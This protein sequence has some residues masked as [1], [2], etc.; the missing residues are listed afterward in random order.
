VTPLGLAAW[1]ALLAAVGALTASGL[2]GARARYRPWTRPAAWAAWGAATLTLALLVEHVLSARLGLFYVWEN[3]EAGYPWWLRLAGVWG[4]QEGTFLLWAWGVLTVLLVED[5][6]T[7]GAPWRH[8]RTV[9]AAIAVL[10]LVPVVVLD[11]G[12]ETLAFGLTGEGQLVQGADGPSPLSLR[13]DGQ[14]L[15]PLLETV[16]MAVHPPLEFLGYA[17]VTAPFAYGLVGLAHGGEWRARAQAWGRVA[18]VVLLSALTL[19]ALWAYHV[20]SFGG[21]WIWDPVEV[22]NLLPLLALTV[23]LHAAPARARGHLGLLA[24]ATAALPLVMVVF[25]DFV[26]RTGLWSSVHAFLPTGVS[27]T[28][29]DPGRRLLAAV[30]GHVPARLATGL[31][32]ATLGAFGVAASLFHVRDRPRGSTASPLALAGALAFGAAG[33][34]GLVWPTVLVRALTPLIG[35]LGLGDPVVGAG[36][37]VV[38]A[39]LP[40]V[41]GLPA[42]PRELP[43]HPRSRA[44]QLVLACGALTVTL[45]ATVLLLVFGVN[46]YGEAVFTARAPWL[47]GATVA[48]VGLAFRPARLSRWAPA[49]GGGLLAGLALRVVTGSWARAALPAVGV[50][51][52][53]VLA[54]YAQVARPTG[55]RRRGG[56]ARRPTHVTHRALDRRLVLTDQVEVRVLCR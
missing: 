47:A 48:G 17:L 38:V 54:R 14:G 40:L 43:T 50:P 56:A 45:A 27:A 23:F 2:A 18:W 39:A 34:V 12:A 16:Y 19:G 6:R 26:V 44:G 55:G 7:S 22:A 5:H 4:G 1:A 10:L 49:V 13:P 36:V 8:A 20:L 25:T 52:A 53:G 21:Y 15:N 42:M 41:A 37:L 35:L 28:L 3:V 31:L 32:S 29:P 30:R 46:G 9:L 33:L 11:L 51:L 24:P